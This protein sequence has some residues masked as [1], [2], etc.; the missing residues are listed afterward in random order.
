MTMMGV[1]MTSVGGTAAATTT[2]VPSITTTVGLRTT[3]QTSPR[4][5]WVSARATGV[6]ATGA[7]PPP[8]Q[9]AVRR[10]RASALSPT[11]APRSGGDPNPLTLTL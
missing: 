2:T 3:Y 11:A 10:R 7:I 9:C 1:S 6:A 8:A 5:R 4:R